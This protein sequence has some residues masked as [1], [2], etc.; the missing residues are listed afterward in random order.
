MIAIRKRKLPDPAEIG[1]SGSF[2]KNPIVTELDFQKLIKLGL[3]SVD[4]KNEKYL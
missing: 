4:L 2:F 1:N 3:S